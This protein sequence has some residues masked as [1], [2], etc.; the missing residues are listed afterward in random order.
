MA[1]SVAV[2]LVAGCGSRADTGS[3][4]VGAAPQAV[5]GVTAS[6]CDYSVA[7]DVHGGGNKGFNAH[8]TV[9]NVSGATSTDFS[10]LVNAGDAQLVDVAHGT[11]QPSEYGYL[12]SPLPSLADSQL[13]Q[14]QTYTFELKFSGAYT[15]LITNIISNNGVDCDQTP[16]T[17]SLTSSGTFFTSNGTLTLSAQ[18]TDDVAVGKV[19]FSQDGSQIASILSPPYSVSIPVTNAINGRHVYTATAYDLSGNQA[20]QSQR[21][22]VAIGNKFFGTAVTTAADYPDLLAHFNQIT[23]GNA[24]KWGSVEAVQG[25]M[26]WTDLDTAYNYA[27]SNNLRFKLHTLVWGSQ[28]PSWITALSPADQLAAVDNWMA[29]IAARYPS[30]DLI[31]VVNEPM[32][33]PP[34]YAA[35]LGGAGATGWDW[36][37]TAFQMA[38]QHF[39]N[40]DLLLNDYSVLPLTSFTQEYLTIVN[41]LQSRG[42]IDGVAEQGHFY[43]RSP[44]PSVLATN[45]AA[46]AATGLPLYISE[47]DLNLSDDARQAQRMSQIFPIFWSNPSVVGVTHWG[48]LQGNMWQADAYLIRSDGSLRPSL[49]WLECYKAGGT[50]CP[51]P[52]YVPQPR[53][54]NSSG[55]TIKAVDYD[56]ANGLLALGSVVA[57]ANDGSWLSYDK[58]SFDSNWNKLNVTYALG[59]TSPINLTISL[60]SLANAPVATVPLAPTGSW[61]TMQTVTI[62]W[63]SLGTVQDMFVRFHGGGA[64]LQTFQFTGPAPSRNLVQNGTFESGTSGWFTWNGGVLSASTARAH[65]GTQSLLVSHRTSN[66][67]AATDLT[68]VVTPGSN[69]PFSLW[70]SINSPN[71]SSQAINVTQAASCKAANGTVSTTYSWVGGPITVPSGATWTQFSGTV[72]VPNCTLALMQFWVEGGVGADLYVDDV[73]VI[74]NSG[75]PV[76]LITDGTFESGQGS[77]FAWGDTSLAVTTTAEHSGTHS[78]LGSGMHN[79]AIARDI[80]SL[81]SPGKRYQA[82]AWVSVGNLA[83]GS[84][85]VNWQTVENC[86]SATSDSYPWLAGATVANGAW[87]KVSGVVDLTACTTINKLLLFAGAASGDLYVDDVSLTALP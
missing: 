13:D 29:A 20:S 32:H 61:G 37:I 85:G 51:V 82:T 1:L 84:G 50:S 54:G 66:A 40:S 46:L 53:V 19:V 52:T 38:R 74:D 18:A 49:T 16:P 80:K 70:V 34:S 9:T 79:G 14:G 83:A 63:T 15:Q 48:Y 65:S 45:L 55:L 67:P 42:L 36:V 24:G 78:L 25:Q 41:L 17:I 69:Y 59:S 56:D 47:L 44:D 21:V 5:T 60:G 28:Q 11:F 64:N 7:A 71:G 86:N 68:S 76:N 4:Q 23:P 3:T 6:T 2:P 33:T 22:L 62:P 10:V 30:I 72:A 81:V 58:V 8:V 57:Y 87:V 73:Q 77:W 31:D 26:N 35:A 75:A 27:K 39:P 43:E 12:L